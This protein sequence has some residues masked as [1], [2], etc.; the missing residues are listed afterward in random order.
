[1][2]KKVMIEVNDVH[3]KFNLASEKLDSFKEVDDE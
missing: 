3:M 1:M 2:E